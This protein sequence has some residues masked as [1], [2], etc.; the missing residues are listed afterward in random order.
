MLWGAFFFQKHYVAGIFTWKAINRK[1]PH[2]TR[3]VYVS[4][5]LCFWWRCFGLYAGLNEYSY[6]THLLWVDSAFRHHFS[7][8]TAKS[9]ELNPRESVWSVL[10]GSVY[11]NEKQ[12]SAVKEV[13]NAVVECWKFLKQN[14]LE[15]LVCSMQSRCVQAT[16]QKT[17]HPITSY[18]KVCFV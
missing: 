16:Q 11:R 6:C 2:N 17:K 15:L 5:C 9:L 13:K 3:A 18:S 4:V 7:S 1:L 14:F 10:A 8:W 12:Y